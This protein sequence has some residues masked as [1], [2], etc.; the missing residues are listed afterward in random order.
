[1]QKPTAQSPEDTTEPDMVVSL[2]ESGDVEE[3]N[4]EYSGVAAF[5]EGQFRRAKDDS[6]NNEEWWMMAVTTIG[7]CTA[8]RWNSRTPRSPKPHNDPTVQ[9]YYLI[10]LQN[11]L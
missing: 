8:L 9:I 7:A 11:A 1:M 5:I 6:V 4:V 2:E 10:C 3:E